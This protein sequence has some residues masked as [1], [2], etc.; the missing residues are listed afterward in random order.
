MLL[1]MNAVVRVVSDT[2]KFECGL[3]AILH[4]KL[5]WLDVTERTQS[6]QAL[7]QRGNGLTQIDWK[8]AVN[9]LRVCDWCYLK[10]FFFQLP[11]AFC[12]HGVAFGVVNEWICRFIQHQLDRVL[13]GA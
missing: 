7:C 13:R 5:H 6:I 4:D 3:K 10:V 8:I 11:D 2:G 9:M 1:P 12:T